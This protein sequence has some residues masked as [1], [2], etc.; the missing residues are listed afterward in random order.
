MMPMQ[1]TGHIYADA[2]NYAMMN[3][4]NASPS[5]VARVR[6]MW[7]LLYE[8][9]QSIPTSWQ[10]ASREVLEQ[11]ELSIDRIIQELSI[12][13]AQSTEPIRY[14]VLSSVL[15]VALTIKQM[16]NGVGRTNSRGRTAVL[17][18]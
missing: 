13:V 7:E 17:A 9:A 10:T 1:Y 12:D 8:L 2:V 15:L 14:H 16:T 5:Q 6:G 18:N 3:A 11:R 4:L